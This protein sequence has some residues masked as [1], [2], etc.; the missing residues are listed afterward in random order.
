MTTFSLTCLVSVFR[1]TPYNSFT[2]N[3]CHSIGKLKKHGQ[4]T[5]AYV[6]L[7]SYLLVLTSYCSSRFRRL[8]VGKEVTVVS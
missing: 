4:V 7:C 3:Y 2:F 6:R 5:D 1:N 8:Q